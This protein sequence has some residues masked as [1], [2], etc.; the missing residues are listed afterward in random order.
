LVGN[1]QNV[2]E[3][4]FNELFPLKI[5]VGESVRLRMEVI[6]N[7]HHSNGQPICTPTPLKMREQDQ[8]NK[9]EERGPK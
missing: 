5:E 8:I 6:F 7:P 4:L 1:C 9:I 3:K 2:E